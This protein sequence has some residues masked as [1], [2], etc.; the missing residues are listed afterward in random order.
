MTSRLLR[1]PRADRVRGLPGSSDH[2]PSIRIHDFY[3]RFI[4][5]DAFPV[6]HYGEFQENRWEAGKKH[7]LKHSHK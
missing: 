6:I 4:L 7:V 5:T 1:A 3:L 2:F